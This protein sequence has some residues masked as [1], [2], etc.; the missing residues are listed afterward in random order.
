M[1]LPEGYDYKKYLPTDEDFAVVLECKQSGR[2]WKLFTFD[3]PPYY[4]SAVRRYLACILLKWEEGGRSIE[5]YALGGHY[6]YVNGVNTLIPYFTEEDL[7]ELRGLAVTYKDWYIDI[8]KKYAPTAWNLESPEK[9]VQKLKDERKG[10]IDIKSNGTGAYHLTVYSMK[11]GWDPNKKPTG[12]PMHIFF[13]KKE[14]DKFKIV[15][16][17]SN[18][19]GSGKDKVKDAPY[20]LTEQEARDFI[21]NVDHNHLDTKVSIENFRYVISN[22]PIQGGWIEVGR[23]I[24][25]GVDYGPEYGHEKINI[26]PEDLVKVDTICGPAYMLKTCKY[27]EE[28][29]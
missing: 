8:L 6:E 14:G 25:N 13:G 28:N 11:Y 27:L 9:R 17:G 18:L 22:Q 20:F 7:A 3:N 21:A 19:Y 16:R 2:T 1:A 5:R 23:R 15:I 12:A 29:L 4:Y 24:E 10:Q 26:L